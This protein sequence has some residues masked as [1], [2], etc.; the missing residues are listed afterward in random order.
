MKIIF[1][2]RGKFVSIDDDV[3]GRDG[4]NL[5]E[6]IV[7]AFEGDAFI[8]GVGR[9][10]YQIGDNKYYVLMEKDDVKKTYSV[11]VKNVMTK[12]GT[13]DLQLVI[14]E[15]AIDEEIPIFKSQVVKVYCARSLNA[16][17]EAPEEYPAWIDTANEK[18]A[19]MDN[20]DIE[21]ERVNDGVEISITDKQG[22]V[23][24]TK[25]NDGEKGDPGEIEE[26]LKDASVS[27]NTLTIVKKDDTTVSFTPSGV[28][29]ITDVTVNGSS[30]V[31]DD[32]ARIEHMATTEDIPTKTSDLRNDSGFITNTD[33]ASQDSGGVVKL[34]SSYGTEFANDKKLRATAVDYSNYSSL[35][36]N[37]FIGKRTLENVITGKGLIKNT[38]YAT[39]DN[40]G[41]IKISNGYGSELASDKKL[42]AT[43]VDYSDYSGLHNNALIGKRTLENVIAGKEL[44]NQTQLNTKQNATDNSL[45]TTNKTIVG[46]INEVNS[47]ALG[48]NQAIAFNNYETM[49][50]TFN[51]LPNTTYKVGQNIYIQT[52][53][54]PDLWVYSVEN[55]SQ[56]YTYT[57]DADL[58]DAILTNGYVQIG[59]YR[60]SELE[61][62]Q[63]DL[64]EYVKNTDYATTAKA[65]AIKANDLYAFDVSG[66]NGDARVRVKT[67]QQYGSLDSRAF[68]CKGTLEN[69]VT[70]KGLVSGEDVTKITKITQDEYDDLT[71]KDV[72]TFYVI[73]G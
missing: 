33:Y 32:I 2:E 21:A 54:V 28:G 72:N 44:V 3:I 34:T 14:T 51:S 43:V 24:I 70:G 5:Q 66:T 31:E 1:N 4:E 25:V 41:V 69:V 56:T 52:L 67:Y 16:E 8:N 58:I 7:C 65:G 53:N 11:P 55:T 10:E 9:L 15:T 39:Q 19:E 20:L 46:G 23:H 37:A 22:V 68:I 64:T 57:T 29:G 49:V 59:Y 71:T 62:Q 6:T 12:K 50:E 61:T 48:N 30:V 60:I 42:R 13:I 27:G 36:N 45:N 47:I 63:V 35:H 17:G 40:A 73:I 18:I 26:Y 38:D